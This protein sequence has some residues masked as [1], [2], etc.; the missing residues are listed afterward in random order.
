MSTHECR[1]DAGS[2]VTFPIQ[3]LCCSSTAVCLCPS[4]VKCSRTGMTML[5][6]QARHRKKLS[7]VKSFWSILTSELEQPEITKE[8]G[9]ITKL[10]A[11]IQVAPPPHCLWSFSIFWAICSVLMSKCVQPDINRHRNLS[12][13]ISKL[14]CR[15]LM[16]AT[17]CPHR[18]PN[19]LSFTSI[20]S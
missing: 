1:P 19:R 18:W 14:R 15:W 3:Q 16:S 4:P 6:C 17:A 9:N 20:G 10:P 12:Q 2:P 7:L 5:L 8:S 11:K 13:H